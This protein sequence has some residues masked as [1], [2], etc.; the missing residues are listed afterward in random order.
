MQRFKSA[1]AAQRLLSLHPAVHNTFYPQRHLISRSTL[2][3]F[4]AEAIVHWTA[5][6]TEA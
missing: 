3:T 4:K 1:G 6:A 2:Q 5:A